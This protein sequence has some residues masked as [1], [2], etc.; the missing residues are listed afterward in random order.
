MVRVVV[1]AGSA[2]EKIGEFEFDQLPRK[3][4]EIS[5]PWADDPHGTRVFSVVEVW[6]VAAG[7]TVDEAIGAGPLTIIRGNEV[8]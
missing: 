1:L 8:L 5:V 7:V 3:D 2:D 4:E 6:H